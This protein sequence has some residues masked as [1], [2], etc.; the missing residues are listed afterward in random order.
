MAQEIGGYVVER[1]LGAGSF[2][3]TPEL[4]EGAA[5]PDNLGA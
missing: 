5:T 4:S 2:G 1:K 3:T